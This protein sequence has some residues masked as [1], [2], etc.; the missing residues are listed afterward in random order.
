MTTLVLQYA[1]AAIGGAIGGPIG[2]AVGRA[3][4]GIAG[5]FVDR[6][7][8]GN[9]ATRRVEGPRLNDLHVQGSSE[10]EPVPVVY[11]RVRLAGQLIWAT[12][13]EEEV[14]TRTEKAGGKGGI[15][16]GPSTKIT[17][18]EYF[19]NFAVGLCEG[20]ITRI[21]RVWA[22]GKE[23]DISAYTHRIHRGT[24]TQQPDSL[25]EAKESSGNAPAYR[26]LAYIVFEKLPLA[27]FGNRL[28]QL[29]FE[30]FRA[31]DDV[32]KKISSVAIIPGLTEFGY[33]RREISRDSGFADDT[34]E[35]NNASAE[36]TDW[37]VSL[38]QLQATCPN[39][40]SVSLVVSWFGS[41]LRCGQCQIKPGVDNKDKKTSPLSWKVS[42]R[43]RSNAYLVSQIDDRAAFGGTPSDDT[44]FEAIADLKARGLKVT[45]YPF[46]I[47][48]VPKGNSLP[49]PYTGTNGQ[50]T[51]PWRGR[52]TCDPAPGRPG[53]PDK[54]SAIDTQIDAFFGAAAAGDF[55][56][57]NRA[58]TYGGA[59]EW[60]FRRMI[61]HYAKLCQAAGGVDA[62]LIGS[63]LR[64][65]TTLRS[66]S[67]TYPVVN[68][69]VSL[70]ADVSS[71]LPGAAISYAADWT[72]YFGHHPQDG[73][74]DVYFHLDPLWGS[75]NID[76]IGI[77]NY[78]PLS[79]WR[80]EPGHLDAAA[81]A[82]SPYEISYLSAN[83][84]GGEG[85]DWYYASQTN[86]DGQI[87]TPITDGAGKPWVFRYKALAQW[88]SNQHYNRP[89]G[90][91]AASPTAWQPRSKPIWFTE[92]GCP[93]VDKGTNQPNVFYDSL[94]DESALPYY[95][96]GTRDDLIQ[97]SYI[98]TTA[99]FWGETATAANP[100]SNVYSGPMIDADNISFWA[101]DARPY[102]AFPYLED[103]WTDGRN[104]EFGHWLNGRL[105]GASLQALVGAILARH[106]FADADYSGLYGL[107]DGFL[108]D[109]PMSAREALEP[110]SLAFF[111]DAVESQGKI[112]F[113]H[114]DQPVVANFAP[115]DLVE[116][117]E[118]ALLYELTRAQE[119]EL[120]TSLSIRYIDGLAD[121]RRA[122][123]GAQRLAGHSARASNADLPIVLSQA[124][125]QQRAEIWLQ[126]AWA[127]RESASLQLPP[128]QLALDAG[129]V[130]H[131][132]A[133]DRITRLQ[134]GE[135]NDQSARSVTA[136]RIDPT[137]FAA[138]AGPDRP[139]RIKPAIVFG[140]A[141]LM[142]MDLPLLSG[143]E[144][145]H[146]GWVAALAKPWPGSLALL[147]KTG[148]S[149]AYQRA[150]NAP[151][152]CGET[153][154]D[155]PSGPPSRFDHGTR[156]QVKMHSGAL[157][158]ISDLELFE[159][160]NAVAIQNS[161]GAWEVLQFRDA[162]LVGSD[163]YELSTF[164][165][166]QAGTETAMDTPVA[167]GAPFVL[168]NGAVVQANL[169]AGDVGREKIWR[170]GPASLDPAAP[171]YRETAHTF[172]GLG[173]RPFSPV[174]VR[175]KTVSAGVEFTWMRR[176]R[177]NGDSWEQL[178]VPL[179]ED[180]ER[181][182]IDVLNG[183]GNPIRLL[184]ASQTSMIYQ[185][186]DI[187][188]DFGAVP[189]SINL[190]IYQVSPTFGRGA[191]GLA[192]I[193][194]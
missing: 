193:Q 45:F 72:E 97:R 104:F 12:Q 61:L 74:S 173:L 176:T 30:I 133:S 161:A 26:G 31:L 67:S 25:I 191:P 43:T 7:L 55:S 56:A 141:E 84:A 50:A 137:L 65:L 168:I 118:D 23:L 120:P 58:V 27:R 39:L 82:R 174:H 192:T 155:L 21:G 135:L 91:E 94:S 162:V 154:S 48:D 10:G 32:E 188:S 95:S 62:F 115:D 145:P 47:M 100:M 140:K 147:T 20:A 42:G 85:Y 139:A 175:G 87:R 130:F 6:A 41:D 17:E 180:E 158:A 19:G 164:L 169:D 157:E 127:S 122:S 33:D 113:R 53:S 3:V 75:P 59:T 189:S 185:T 109:R 96:S 106:G 15:A 16:S 83:V 187:V 110:L 64:E 138:S 66:S 124:A 76:F 146:D 183:S 172:L 11:G 81:G 9:N 129:D 149:L 134:I 132:A 29:S 34:P 117:N 150:I 86:R 57:S 99:T 144:V 167:A 90:S 156:L 178:D 119:T 128:S 13:F 142:F 70:A 2:A 98:D 68:H 148:S 136:S 36:K 152:T 114:K 123:V 177:I 107:M 73:S 143:A 60:S 116:E 194:L 37:T 125:A 131:L 63:E 179:A 163:T 78:M 92:A 190:V 102:P 44:V 40:K 51:Y 88:W 80:D 1:G 54:S 108:I 103:I 77:D 18:Y 181:Y 89:G 52:I 170:Y 35:N 171:S 79:D 5:Q 159:G 14:S 111:F 151:A 126:H 22:D 165:R 4:G 28:P 184:E 71:V 101:W 49:D 160:G 112:V 121:Y 186:S 105:G 69:L 46:I 93:A 8:F 166:G 182:Q 24:Q 153:L 38:D